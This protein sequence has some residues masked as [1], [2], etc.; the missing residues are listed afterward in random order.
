LALGNF[1]DGRDGPCVAL[2]RETEAPTLD[3][4]DSC[5]DH[6]DRDQQPEDGS[7]QQHQVQP[8]IVVVLI[9][10]VIIILAV[11]TVI[12]MIS[13]IPMV[14]VITVGPGTPVTTGAPAWEVLRRPRQERRE[15]RAR[16]LA[17]DPDAAVGRAPHRNRPLRHRAFPSEQYRV[18]VGDA[19]RFH[20][21]Q[22]EIDGRGDQ[23][24]ALAGSELDVVRQ[25]VVATVEVA[26]LPLLAPRIKKA[27]R[28]L[29][30]RRLAQSVGKVTAK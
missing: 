27:M 22:L 7:E 5:D 29:E 6:A 21:G 30:T 20:P 13:A 3:T 16:E 14:T 19:P 11:L 12:P 4:F 25:V 15:F 23:T 28:S 18:Y 26:A 17:E 10:V 1:V 8:S 24:A 2:A 9:I